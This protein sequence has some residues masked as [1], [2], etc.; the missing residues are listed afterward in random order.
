MMVKVSN[1]VKWRRGRCRFRSSTFLVGNVV[2]LVIYSAFRSHKFGFVE[3]E[4]I[5]MAS[6]QAKATRV[7]KNNDGESNSSLSFISGG[8]RVHRE[9]IEGRDVF[10]ASPRDN[11]QSNS[12][13]KSESRIKGLLFLAHGCEHSNLDWFSRKSPECE[14]CLGLP[15]ESAI[16]EIA[17]EMGLVAIAMSSSNRKTKCWSGLDITPVALVL[18]E[19]WHRFSSAEDVPPPPRLPLYAF[20]ASDGGAFVSSLASPLQSRFGIR[21][22]GFVSQ[23]A[24][25]LSLLKED[26]QDAVHDLCKVYVTMNRDNRTDKA[27]QAMVEKCQSSSTTESNS[28]VNS[29]I[30]S[31]TQCQHIRLPPRRIVP[32]YF[33]NRIQGIS[34]AESEEMAKVLTEAGILGTDNGELIKEPRQSR[35]QWTNALWSAAASASSILAFQKR[36][37]R[38]IPDRSPISEVLNVAWGFHEISRDGVR[39]AL[40]FCVARQSTK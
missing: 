18:N 36:G 37:D 17:L 32:S 16:V 5:A 14:D 28:G 7:S 26:E 33:A 6:V 30:K 1:S 38:F 22:D 19:L 10:W 3:R 13:S 2:L 31:N 39:E 23:I 35:K 40:E 20:G 11:P 21:L 24:A 9:T 25:H 8:I 12:N 15:E 29:T 27:A 34:Q 4:S